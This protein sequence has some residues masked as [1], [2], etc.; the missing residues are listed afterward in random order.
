MLESRDS[1][2][3]KLIGSKWVKA[4]WIKTEAD[5]MFKAKAFTNPYTRAAPPRVASIQSNLTN[6]PESDRV[7]QI[8]VDQSD[9]TTDIEHIR[10]L[11]GGAAQ[12]TSSPSQYSL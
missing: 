4:E 2:Y 8:R 3:S 9:L 6:S 1:L 11:S 10:A 5:N 12:D 7:S